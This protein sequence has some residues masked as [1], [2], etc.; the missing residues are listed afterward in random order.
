V[1]TLL[2]GHPQITQITQMPRTSGAKRR[3]RTASSSV[4][5]GMPWNLNLR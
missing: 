1:G 5:S 3:Q 2:K 4:P